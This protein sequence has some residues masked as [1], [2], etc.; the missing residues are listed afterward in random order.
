SE[1]PN[2][3][4]LAERRARN[5]TGAACSASSSLSAFARPRGA[6]GASG[7]AS[8]SKPVGNKD[9]LPASSAPDFSQLRRFIKDAMWCA[10]PRNTRYARASAAPGSASAAPRSS[11]APSRLGYK[12]A[13]A[14]LPRRTAQIPLDTA[15]E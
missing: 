10:R 6:V 8:A 11:T 9:T 15:H 13:C 3:F 2:G 14:N 12:A 4:S 1:G 7:A 5:C